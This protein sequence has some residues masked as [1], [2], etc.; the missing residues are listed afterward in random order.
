MTNLS[1]NSTVVFDP[2][3]ALILE[4]NCKKKERSKLINDLIRTYFKI[5][6]DELDQNLK[7][8][9]DELEKINIQKALLEANIIN[10]NERI[11]MRDEKEAERKKKEEEERNKPIIETTYYGKFEGDE[12]K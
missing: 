12:F 3:V 1:F 5:Q 2:D 9:I 11:K 8:N 7:T 6:I 4:K 10:I